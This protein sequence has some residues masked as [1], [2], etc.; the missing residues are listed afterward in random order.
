MF[1]FF[2]RCALVCVVFIWGTSVFAQNGTLK[3][4]AFGDIYYVAQ[5]ADA[6][7]EG[8]A[9]PVKALFPAADEVPP[10]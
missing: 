8:E 2:A 1:R 6:D 3:G 9:A 5:N 7:L 10:C 4:Y